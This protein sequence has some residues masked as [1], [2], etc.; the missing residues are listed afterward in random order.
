[1]TVVKSLFDKL[2][3]VLKRVDEVRDSGAVILD[4][5]R[6]LQLD[7][8][9]CGAQSA[10]MNLRY[11]GRGRSP[12]AVG[13]ALG[14]NEDGTATGPIR[15]LFRGRGLTPVINGRARLRHLIAAIDVG[16]PALVSL[17]DGGHW[18]VV[19]GYST[20]KIYLADPSMKRLRVGVSRRAFLDRWDHWAMVVS[21]R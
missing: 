5:R 3:G 17:A 6:S 2:D 12:V 18:G 13:R 14:T 16:A 1:M 7:S 8:F 19:Y 4:V 10:Y 20:E 21:R 9:S 11:Y 15:D